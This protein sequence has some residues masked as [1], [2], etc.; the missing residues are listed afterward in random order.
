MGSQAGFSS[1]TAARPVLSSWTSDQNP[2]LSGEDDML[3]RYSLAAG[4]EQKR[5]WYHVIV[6]VNTDGSNLLG[7]TKWV[8]ARYRESIRADRNKSGDESERAEIVSPAKE[9]EWG[10]RRAAW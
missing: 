6:I 10:R 5:R 7:K 2:F 1:P 9:G 3:R 8:L 4:H